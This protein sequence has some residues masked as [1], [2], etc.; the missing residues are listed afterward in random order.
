MKTK[1]THCLQNALSLFFF[2]PFGKQLVLIISPLE[3]TV[4]L[5][6]GFSIRR[7]F[8]SSTCTGAF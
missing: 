5:P 3:C 6:Q 2:F 7:H 4:C 1:A 8:I